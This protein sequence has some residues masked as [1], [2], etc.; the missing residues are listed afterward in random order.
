[1]ERD[2]PKPGS[3]P[4]PVLIPFLRHTLGCIL[5]I[6]V[7]RPSKKGKIGQNNEF[8]HP[9]SLPG[10]GCLIHTQALNWFTHQ[11]PVRSRL[12]TPLHHAWVAN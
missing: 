12:S 11:N 3:N 8:L 4:A 6:S 2:V 5:G 1:M 9:I 10:Y 7:S